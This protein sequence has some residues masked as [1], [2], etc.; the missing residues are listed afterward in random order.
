MLD[1]GAY[2]YAKACGIIGK[3]FLG[4]RVSSLAG[5]H[6]L[7][8]LDRLVFRE[9]QR[10]LPVRELLSDLEYRIIARAVRQI[11][12]ITSSFAITPELLVRM[13]RSYEYSDLKICIQNIA[14]G[15]KEPPN[16]CDIGRFAT[17]SF[18]AF[19]DIAAMLNN[20][21][22]APFLS[23]DLKS[24]QAGSTDT[25]AVETKLD[26]LYYQGLINSLSQLSAEDRLITQ[27]LLA[28]EISLRNC[29]WALR[30]RTYYHKGAEETGKYLMD[31]KLK[32]KGGRGF[33]LA[34][35]AFES[36]DFPLD[37]RNSWDGWKWE[38]LLNLEQ[39]HA[40]WAADPRHFQNAASGYLY[41]LAL[42]SFHRLPLST[43]AIF[44][45][46]KLKQFE[47]DLLTS[48]AEGLA[49]GMDSTNI[50]RLLEVSS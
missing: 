23:E 36:L 32:G 19:P 8:E 49:L 14:A 30:L 6:N 45:F 44:C 21:E 15:K 22:F 27:R 3:S 10:E 2:A 18:D 24:I 31:I 26:C 29:V 48:L 9:H 39:P 38:K 46:I 13:I 47:E 17:V 35:D 5:L 12:V 11:L 50:F 42:R 16:I 40:H 41:R 43:S 28:E 33:S 34:A 20:T 7:S 37:L 4:K 1:A 25:V